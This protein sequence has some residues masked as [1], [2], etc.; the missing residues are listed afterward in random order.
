MKFRKW[1]V[2]ILLV[3]YLAFL[4]GWF[5]AVVAKEYSCNSHASAMRRLAAL[6]KF[7]DRA[8]GCETIAWMERL[9]RYCCDD[10]LTVMDASDGTVFLRLIPGGNA[11]DGISVWILLACDGNRIRKVAVGT[12]VPEFQKFTVLLPSPMHMV[13]TPHLAPR[14]APVMP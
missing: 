7:L 3:G 10:E 6:Q 8:P 5:V 14:R 4:A 2:R 1:L 11:S 9:R 13:T 12:Y